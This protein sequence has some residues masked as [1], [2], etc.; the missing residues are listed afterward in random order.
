MSWLIGYIWDRGKLCKCDILTNHS[1]NP[2][3]KPRSGWLSS[4]ALIAPVGLCKVSWHVCRGFCSENCEL[5][6]LQ[7]SSLQTGMWYE[8]WT[9]GESQICE[10][11]EDKV[12]T[13]GTLLTPILY[14]VYAKCMLWC[15][16]LQ[17]YCCTW[18]SANTSS[19]PCT[20]APVRLD[21]NSSTF[22]WGRVKL[23]Y[24]QL[25]GKNCTHSPQ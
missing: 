19:A 5:N 3:M 11:T 23:N 15:W 13:G 8:E 16:V 17:E 22:A 6:M 9:L 14:R 1:F 21:V 4:R 25:E 2:E 7:K 10:S 20:V 18:S 12:R 24:S